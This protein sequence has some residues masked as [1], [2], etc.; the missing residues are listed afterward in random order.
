MVSSLGM[1]NNLGVAVML[2]SIAVAVAIFITTGIRLDTFDKYQKYDIILDSHTRTELEF[3]HDNF[4]P[5]FAMH[6]ALGV[7]TIIA[8]VGLLVAMVSVGFNT[9]PVS[10]LLFAIGFSVFLFVSASMTKGAYYILLGKGEY[11]NKKANRRAEEIVGIVASIYWPLTIAIFLFWGF[12]GD[13]WGVNFVIFPIAGILFGAFS[14]AVGAYAR[15]K[16]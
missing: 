12:V 3:M 7:A 16:N 11:A 2:L 10:I 6:I 14:S 1:N 13:G 15:N 4:T 5:R 8:A 9:L